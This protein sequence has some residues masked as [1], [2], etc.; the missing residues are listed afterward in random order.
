MAEHHHQRSEERK[1][2][3]IEAVVTLD[4]A[5]IACV[6]RDISRKGAK[7]EA[8][9]PLV[10][11]AAIALAIGVFGTAEGDV[12]WTSKNVAGIKFTTDPEEVDTILIKLAT[13]AMLM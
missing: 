6:L 1:E 7:V 4:G 3:S 11:G 13:Y 8:K 5:E 10:K 9:R 2:T 12:V